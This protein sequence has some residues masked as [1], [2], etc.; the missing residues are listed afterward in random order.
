MKRAI[1][2]ALALAGC[3]VGPDYEPP[4]T[5]APSRWSQA[6]DTSLADLSTWWTVFSDA[7]LNGL[8]DRAVRANHDV[9][10]AVARVDEARAQLGVV[11]G[12]LLPQVDATADWSKRRVSPNAQPFNINQI[13][14]SRYTVGFDASWEID[15]F[16]GGRRRI[17]AATAD[18]EA[19]NEN[20]RPFVWTK[21]EVH[22]KRLKA[23][24]ADQ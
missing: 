11:R 5:D 8:I 23:R 6:A 4:K 21:S 12:Y 15:I 10:I 20:P 9:R 16:G 1:V 19:W 7:T 24:F 22:Q 3:S 18:L 17:E 14:Q 13:Y 2:V